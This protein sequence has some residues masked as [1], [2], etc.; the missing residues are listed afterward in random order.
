MNTVL[1]IVCILLSVYWIVLFARIIMSW[2]SPPMSGLGR[3]IWDLIHD[4]TEPVLGL[5]RGLLPPVRMGMVGLD[6]SPI[7]VF[8]ALGII[9]GALCERRF[10]LGF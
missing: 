7:L 6:L 2:F 10:G 9:Q 1:S 8:V 4:V 5:V 3:T